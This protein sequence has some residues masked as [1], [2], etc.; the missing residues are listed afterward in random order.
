MQQVFQVNAF[1]TDLFS[2]NP[3][4]VCP[5][6]QWPSDALMRRIAAESRL[7]CAFFVGGE[8]HYRL[9]WFTPT[10]EIEGICGH[11]TLAAGFVV[12]NELGEQS[13][14]VTFQVPAG[15]LRVRRAGD[16]YILDLPALNP[17]PQPMPDNLADIL[18]CAPQAVLGA[19]DLIAVLPF[20]RQGRMW[21]SSSR[22]LNQC[23]I[24]PY[25][26]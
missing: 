5:L 10:N 15:E 17:L 14:E 22:T 21:P 3:A 8:G 19:L 23:S 7:T 16:S 24:S 18:G 1:T 12:L 13:D 2:G 25:G 20:C 6:Q 26:H 4:L 11:G 9:R